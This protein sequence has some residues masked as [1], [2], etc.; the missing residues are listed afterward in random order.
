MSDIFDKDSFEVIVPK[1]VMS[2]DYDEEDEGWTIQVGGYELN[3][4]FSC[5]QAREI[6]EHFNPEYE[7]QR[8]KD[9]NN[10]TVT[11]IKELEES[12]KNVSQD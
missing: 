1:V 3:D 2:F 7:L 10:T 6:L 12:L 4:V 8:L 5:T 9:L 11:R